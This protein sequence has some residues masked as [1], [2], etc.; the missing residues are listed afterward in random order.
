MEEQRSHQ[1]KEAIRMRKC[2]LCECPVDDHRDFC[3][4][5][6]QKRIRQIEE[7][8]EKLTVIDKQMLEYWKEN[9][10]PN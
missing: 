3:T 10:I 8:M 9:K 4:P 2:L 6:Y 5:C 1:R 7:S